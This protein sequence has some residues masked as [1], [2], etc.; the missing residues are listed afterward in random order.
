MNNFADMFSQAE[1]RRIIAEER[2]LSTYRAFAEANA[3][4]ELGGRFAKLHPTSVVGASPN[5][6]YP[7][8]PLTSTANQAM[9]AGQT[10]APLGFSVNDMEPV[11]EKHEVAASSSR[12]VV[13]S[14]GSHEA[15]GPVTSKGWRRF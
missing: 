1:R 15:V 10:E 11:G 13:V 7:R 14:D 4:L 12:D 5:H 8:Q 2:R 9:M 6:Q 3:D